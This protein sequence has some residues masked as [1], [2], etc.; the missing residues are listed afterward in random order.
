MLDWNYVGDYTGAENGIAKA[1][2]RKGDGKHGMG[3]L[4]DDMWKVWRGRKMDEI[5]AGSLL[6]VIVAQGDN[7]ASRAIDIGEDEVKREKTS[8][9]VFQ[10]GNGPKLAGKYIPV[11]E[12]PRM[13]SVEVINAKYAKRK[14]FEQSEDVKEQGF[15]R[16]EMDNIGNAATG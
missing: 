8:Q 1:G 12:K 6:D 10:G 4:V 5:L 13:E 3:G 15:R 14:G 9:K 7:S 16:V 2:G 11:M